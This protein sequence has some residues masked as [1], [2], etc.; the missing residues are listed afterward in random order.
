MDSMNYDYCNGQIHS[1]EEGDTLYNLSRKYHV[2]L[3]MLLRANPYVDVYNLQIGDTICIPGNAKPPYRPQRPNWFKENGDVDYP[4][5]GNDN[6]EDHDEKEPSPYQTEEGDSLQT[7]ADY[8]G[9]G[10]AALF[11]CNDPKVI[12]LMPG[13]KFLPPRDDD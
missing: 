9:V 3:A 4:D 5:D 1:I 11:T 10:P 6:Y 12:L 8:F 2:P 13:V 7:V